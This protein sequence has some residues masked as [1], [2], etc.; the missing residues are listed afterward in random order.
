MGAPGSGMGVSYW[1]SML[2]TTQ[3]DLD[4]FTDSINDRT[5]PMTA[6]KGGAIR[7]AAEAR[8]AEVAGRRRDHRRL[9]V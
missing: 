8:Q 7:R 2:L 4:E 5:Y 3:E 9:S 1:K 6:G